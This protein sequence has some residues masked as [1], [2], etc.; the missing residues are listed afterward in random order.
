MY[1]VWTSK[2]LTRNETRAG[3]HVNMVFSFGSD[4][5]ETPAEDTV[6]R[7]EYTTL[8]PCSEFWKK[9]LFLLECL[10]N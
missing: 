4:A 2:L 5:H 9:K 3:A 1:D 10:M 7:S 8:A 6:G